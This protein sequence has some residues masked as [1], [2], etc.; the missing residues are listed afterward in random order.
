M[1]SSSRGRKL[2]SP[3]EPYPDR[4]RSLPTPNTP[5]SIVTI[6]SGLLMSCSFESNEVGRDRKQA[7][8]SS[9]GTGVPYSCLKLTGID[10]EVNIGQVY[11]VKSP[12][13]LHFQGN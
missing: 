2:P 10:F 7:R 3:R 13:I 11:L 9:R 12:K 1:A 8:Y 5:D 6:I 4:F